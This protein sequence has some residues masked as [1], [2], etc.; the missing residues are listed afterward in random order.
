MIMIYLSS[1]WC[2][3][4]CFLYAELFGKIIDLHFVPLLCAEMVQLLEVHAQEKLEH[5]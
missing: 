5:S 4:H 1:S 2:I 3:I